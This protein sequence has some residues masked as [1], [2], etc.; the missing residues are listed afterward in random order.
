MTVIF[1]ILTSVHIF[2]QRSDG[3]EPIAIY[4][5]IAIVTH[6]IDGDTIVVDI[7]GN[8]QKVRLIGI[9]CPELDEAYG[10]EA[11]AFLIEEIEGE[12]VY[13]TKDVRETDEYDR[14]LRYIWTEIPQQNNI[15]VNSMINANILKAG[16]AQTMMVVPDTAYAK[17]FEEIEAEAKS[18]NIGLWQSE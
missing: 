2:N 4:N 17:I 7:E 15:S 1:L 12:S 9:D 8:S 6:V 14:L 3:E 11:K 5:E 10:D 18:N 13:L 16:Y